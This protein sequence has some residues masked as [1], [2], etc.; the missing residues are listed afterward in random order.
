MR[1]MPTLSSAS[2]GFISRWAPWNRVVVV[3]VCIALTAS[4][5]AGKAEKNHPQKAVVHFLATGMLLRGTWGWN[6]DTYLAELVPKSGGMCQLARILDEYP[7]FVPP[8]TRAT[9]IAK[10]GTVLRIRRD[11]SCDIAYT[12]LHLRTAPGDPLAVVPISLN[13]QPQID[14]AT[15]VGEIL[16]CYRIMRK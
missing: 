3:F 16:P 7:S 1:V 14:T 8:L 12:A 9:L 5:H 2:K 6:E 4:S 15:G 13:Y 10:H 11:T